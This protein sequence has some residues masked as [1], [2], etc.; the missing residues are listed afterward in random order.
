LWWSRETVRAWYALFEARWRR[1]Y[2]VT[3]HDRW[4]ILGGQLVTPVSRAKPPFCMWNPALQQLYCS[5]YHLA[6]EF[7][8]YYID[9]LRRH[10]ITYLFGYT[11]ALHTLACEVLRLGVRDLAMRVVITNAE[12]LYPHQ[13]AAISEAFQCPVRETYGMAEIVAAAGECDRGR[14]HLWPE[15][16]IVQVLA[17]GRCHPFGESGELI[18]T[19]LFNADMPLIRYRVGDHGTVAHPS[20]ACPCGRSLPVLDSIEGRVDDMVYT[21]DGRPVGRLDP[22][23]KARLPLL[24]AQIIQERLDFFRV[25]YVPG[26]GCDQS[27]EEEIRSRL[28]DRVG[29]VDVTFQPVD[30][31]PRGPNGKFKAVMSRIPNG[32][33]Q[34][35][36]CARVS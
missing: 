29:A 26:P 25:V 20:E 28:R 34:I 23:F 30:R 14:L 8:Q 2:G 13:R 18:A 4:A 9:A 6:S 31:I 1:W 35:A 36:E 17:K 15:A 21:A 19:G 33:L 10:R 12:P 24:E 32:Q 3:R 11:S 5:S 16:G 27:T 7:I 22:I